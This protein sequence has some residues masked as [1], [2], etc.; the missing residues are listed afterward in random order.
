MER[1]KLRERLKQERLPQR[2]L[3][4]MFG[5]F[6]LAIGVSFAVRSN[7]GVS[8]VQSMPLVLTYITGLSMGVCVFLIFS[9]YT[10][11]Q[12]PILGRKFQWYQLAQVPA[13][14][15]FGYLVDLTQFLL[16]DFH[17]PT[18]FGQ[19]AKLA[20]GVFLIA[21]GI[22]LHMRPKLINQPPDALVAAVATKT[23][24]GAFYRAKIGTDLTL[25]AVSALLSFVFLGG[26]YGL[27]E[28]TVIAAVMIGKCIPL[29][30]RIWGPTLERLGFPAKS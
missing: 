14:L 17:I 20:I 18:Y 13:A 16:G 26:L 29:A 4:Y 23:K 5:L 9:A 15:V 28:G 24:S 27:R 8:P 21:N 2:V 6:I 19:L 7:L 11:A 22:I 1:L 25:V 12:I 30:N 3:L 10:L